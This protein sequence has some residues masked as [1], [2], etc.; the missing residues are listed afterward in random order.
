MFKH[1]VGGGLALAGCGLAAVGGGDKE[2]EVVI[3]LR[4]DMMFGTNEE[5]R[6]ICE[7]YKED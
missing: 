2:R 5:T 7:L 4:K 6:C 1:I 3:V